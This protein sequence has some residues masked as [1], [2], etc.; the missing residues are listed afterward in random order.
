MEKIAPAVKSLKIFNENQL[1]VETNAF[2]A[3]LKS[4]LSKRQTTMKLTSNLPHA[5][6][7]VVVLGM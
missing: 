2:V 5:N 6:I 7:Y 3:K 4:D 1:V